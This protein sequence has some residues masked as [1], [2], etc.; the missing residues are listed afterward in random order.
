M[1]PPIR[2]PSG[3]ASSGVENK[4]KKTKAARRLFDLVLFGFLSQKSNKLYPLRQVTER[5]GR[6]Q[7]DH[8]QPPQSSPLFV[9]TP[10]PS[11]THKRAR[12]AI[13]RDEA[14]AEA[15]AEQQAEGAE[16]ARFGG[17]K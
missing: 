10:L 1:Q 3:P 2:R 6:G 4:K 7:R 17:P 15:W 5:S 16:E 9:S 14:E 11:A 8:A 12:S 13:D